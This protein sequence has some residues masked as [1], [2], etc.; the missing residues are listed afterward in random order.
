MKIDPSLPTPPETGPARMRPDAVPK[1]CGKGG[2]AA[3]FHAPGM[4]WAGVKRA[5]VAHARIRR[6]RT[7]A[8]RGLPGVV[9]VLTH[10]DVRGTNRQ[11]VVRKD[12]P[13]LADDKV[14]HPGDGVALVVAENREALDRALGRITL[15]ADPLPGVFDVESALRTDSP[16]I[17]EDH[18]TGNVLLSG[19]LVTG[20]GEKALEGCEAVVELRLSTA[21]QEHAYLETEAGWAVCEDDG[22]LKI[23]VST[24]TPFRDRAE[25]ADALGVP[26]ETVRILAPY[27]GGAFGG[28]DGITVQSLLGLA[29]LH[30]PGRPVKMWWGR[31][32]SFLAGVKRHPARLHYRLGAGADGTLHALRADITYDTGP[33]DHLG[34]AVMTLGLEHAAGPYRIPN[35]DLRAWAVYTNNPVGGAFRGFGVPQVAAAMEQAM[36]LLAARLEMCPLK[37]RSKNA[38][39]AGDANALGIPL[40]G[41]IALGDC[42][43]GVRG[44]RLWQERRQWKAGAGPM[45]SRG[46][47]LACVLHA[48]GYG[49]V[50]PDA[51]GARIEF[52]REGKFRVDCGVVDMGQG[53][54]GTFL[55]IAADVLNQDAGQM[56]LVLPDTNRTLP[57]GSASASRTTYTFGNALIGAARQLRRR[58]LEKARESMAAAGEAD[59]ALIPGFA[60]CRST[61][62]RIGL[63]ELCGRFSDR[64]RVVTQTFTA[65]TSAH[66]APTSDPM[67]RTLGIPHLLF[68][69]A[70][71]LAAV[72]VDRLTGRVRVADYLA[73]T[74]AGRQISPELFEQQIQGGVAQG[75]GYA[76]YEEFI[77]ERGRGRTPDFSTYLLPTALDLPEM[78]SVAVSSEEPTGPFGLKGCGEIAMDAPLPAIANAVA[79]ACGIRLEQTPLT[80]ERVLAALEKKTDKEVVR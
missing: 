35:I 70:V 53:N 44:H 6:I 47:G 74:D 64:E 21:C 22:T 62:Q 34:G 52:T 26:V 61:G 65:P 77:T 8:A 19:G 36:D 9:A 18:D 15:E 14:R 69:Y 29:A 60:E 51:A 7:A 12:Q 67:L 72:E 59:P 48:M 66:A 32:E 27:C 58:I 78:T 3:D 4:L 33:Y 10:R 40:T 31:E 57:S 80:A 46:V 54:A 30:C 73:L 76:L 43:E 50:I 39:A 37:L 38:L 24:Q 71:H 68:S 2:Y 13:V 79:D 56:T 5:G 63:K 55:K 45:T 28:K 17:H 42:L 41:S 1:A 23:T 16:R 20:A 49:P 25:V 75:I 11:G